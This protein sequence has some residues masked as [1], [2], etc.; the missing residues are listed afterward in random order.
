MCK[1]VASILI[2]VCAILKHSNGAI[3][4]DAFEICTAISSALLAMGLDSHLSEQE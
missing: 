2:F 3:S 4:N 1:I